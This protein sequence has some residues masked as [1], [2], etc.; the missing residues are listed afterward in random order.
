MKFACNGYF[1][2][3]ST[4][5]DNFSFFFTTSAL[6]CTSEVNKVASPQTS[7]GVRLSRIHFSPTRDKRTPKDVCGEA[8]YISNCIR[9]I[10]QTRRGQC[11]HCNISQNCVSKCTKL[12]ASQHIFISKH[13]RGSMPP[14]PPWKL[15]A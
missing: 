13:F 10:I 3:M 12:I 7:F 14:D 6:K 4:E 11:T 9:K 2:S 8:K 1:P 5:N 15:V